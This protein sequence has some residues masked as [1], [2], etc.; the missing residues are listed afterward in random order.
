MYRQRSQFWRVTAHIRQNSVIDSLW[1][2]FV[3]PILDILFPNFIFLLSNSYNYYVA[4]LIPQPSYLICLLSIAYYL[5]TCLLTA[6]STL[7]LYGS[8]FMTILASQ[9]RPSSSHSNSSCFSKIQST[10]VFKL[11]LCQRYGRKS[12]AYCLT[13]CGMKSEVCSS[14]IWCMMPYDFSYS[15]KFEVLLSELWGLRSID[16]KSDH[17]GLS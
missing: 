16:L 9:P 10:P 14:Q 7:L 5:I 1:V 15:L 6:L 4:G 12:V 8:T 3:S 13:I 2:H 11:R 17:Y